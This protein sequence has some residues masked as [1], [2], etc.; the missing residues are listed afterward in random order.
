[1]VAGSPVA[2]DIVKC[3]LKAVDRRDYARR[4]TAD[5]MRRLS[6]IFPDGVC[7]WSRP[8]VGQ[9]LLKKTWLS[10]PGSDQSDDG[11]DED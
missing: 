1:M 3:R 11:E 10:L 8:G 6:T 5:Q 2:N 9:R 4:L 7:D